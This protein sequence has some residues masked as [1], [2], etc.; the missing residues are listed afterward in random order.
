MPQLPPPN[1]IPP[2]DASL[3]ELDRITELAGDLAG[4]FELVPLLER[5]LGHAVALLDCESGSISIVYE[6]EGYYRKEVDRG[7]GCHQ[8]R[9]FPL[10]E[11]LTGQI[12]ATRGTVILDRYA[13]VAVGHIDPAD[14]RWGSA[15]IGVPILWD[16]TIIGTFAIFSNGPGRVFSTADA[17]L[18]ELFANH[19]AIAI[20][21]ARLHQAAAD[22]QREVAVAAERE[23]AVQAVHE[24]IGR[25]LGSVLLHLDRADKA[26]PGGSPAIEYI[27]SAR[28]LAHEALFE[29]RRTVLGLAPSSL[30]GSTLEEAVRAELDRVGS[31]YP[32]DLTLLV[33]GQRHEPAPVVAH[34][35]F[36]VIQEAVTNVVAHAHATTC[37]VGIF[38]D[39]T[40]M[41]VVVEDNGR[42]F[43]RPGAGE[44]IGT[45]QSSRFGLHGMAARAHYLRGEL[46]VESTPG[47]GTSIRAQV[48]YSSN[49]DTSW[50]RWKVV[51][52]CAQP[53]IR[54]GLVRLLVT[55]E[56]SV[57]VLGELATLRDLTEAVSLLQPDMIV[58]DEALLGQYAETQ[59]SSGDTV[60][61]P[62]VAVVDHPTDE[63]LATA[64]SSGVRGFISLSSTPA[65]VARV[66]VAAARGDALLDGAMFTRLAETRQTAEPV[67]T[68]AHLTARELEVRELLAEGLADKQ[69]A[70]RLGISVKTVEKHV[71]AMLRKT[72]ARNRTM[73]VPLQQDSYQ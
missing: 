50:E 10:T 9:T 68:A 2:S 58:L 32:I 27:D 5:V 6:T 13:S 12:V 45:A 28:V 71:G 49:G 33:T 69:I 66:V 21:N 24:T 19:A 54:A 59:M 22:R 37:R 34:Q 25:S 60:E 70:I 31:S 56:P 44:R 4:R 16:G 20:M 62:I 18:V 55:S 46:L 42:G 48:P 1:Q 72:G 11:G 36:M 15:V 3:S 29:T 14:P 35:L 23:R 57:Q 47:W 64:A 73:L 30:V 51:V 17:S 53:L 52:A 40:G 26:T 38:Y 61:R 63:Q 67:S 43:E 7:V 8:G 39:T 65:E 41:T